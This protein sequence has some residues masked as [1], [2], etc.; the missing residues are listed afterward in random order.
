MAGYQPLYIRN[1]QVGLV[2]SRENFLLPEDAY[3][4]LENALI[5]RERIQRKY[6]SQ[7]LGRL[8]R[9]LTA[10]SF[11]N[12]SAAGA[13]KFTFD[14]GMGLRTATSI[15]A[16]ETN[17]QITPGNIVNFT[18]TIGAP[19][20]QTLTD[21]LGT[22]VLT[23]TGAGPITSASIS[24]ASTILTL[25]FSGVAGASAATF[26]GDYYPT[27]SVM[28]LRTEELVN[29]AFDQTIA[30]DTVYS[31]VYDSIL[32]HYVEFEPGTTWTGSTTEFFW[33]TNYWISA[34][35][36]KIFWVTN[37][38]DPIRFTNGQT[39]SQ[40]FNFSPIIN[41]A[42]ALLQN[43][44][45][46][47]PYRGRLV[48]FNTTESG[49][50][51]GTFTNRIRWAAIGTP[52][53]QVYGAVI[54]SFNVNAW[55]DDIRGQGGFL[56]IPTSEDITAVG[57]V[58]DNCV[59]YCERSTWQLRYTGR[60]IAPFIIERVNS[61]LGAQSLFS[62]V[63]FDTSLVGIGDK[64]IVE[65]DSYKS[66][67]IDTKI[68]DL[69]FTFSNQNEDTS[70]VHGIRDFVSRIAYWTYLDDSNNLSFPNKR[71]VY[72]YYNDSWAI[73]D[74]SF[75]C[76]GTFQLT[77]ERTWLNTPIPWIECDF[78][79]LAEP[80]GDPSIVAGNQQGFVQIVGNQLN[81]T[82][83]N[84]QSLSIANITPNVT[85][86]TEL[87]VPNHNLVT[88]AIIL[89]SGILTGTSF[90]NLNGG[91]FS[92]IVIDANN[93]L[94]MIY[95]AEDGQFSLPQLDPVPATPYIGNGVIAIRDNFDI[96]SKKFNV[97]EQGQS[98]QLGYID[99]LMDAT[100]SGAITLN[101]YMDYQ[102]NAAT[103]AF[104]QNEISGSDPP[105][106]D[107]FFNTIIQ[108]SQNGLNTLGG[109]KFFQRVFCPT[110]ANFITIEFTLSNAQ[111]NG[112]EQEQDVQIDSQ[113]IWARP[114]GRLTAG[115]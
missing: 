23:I 67:R 35:H 60:S 39:G 3:P 14:I 42:G 44:L 57:F 25:T 6:G 8:E 84:Q 37:N 111:M 85:T 45:A 54:T 41:A 12:I 51:G 17:A 55:R 69:V 18:I 75:T 95:N 114:A 78:T 32:N 74:D 94:L 81:G 2:Q 56:D 36:F 73:F 49:V 65:C 90:A 68:P 22:G 71:L 70:N 113:V 105:A 13:G 43:A 72:N 92:I 4:I 96:V 15:T 83:T 82:T 98:I 26:T 9:S 88:G 5:F 110:R 87:T 29:S 80:S 52:F 86:A 16:A 104:P 19:I 20:S 102:N 76:F 24:Y 107:D 109:E 66:E 47:L 58:R 46:L 11:G 64:G 28:G 21:T 115:Y 61:E 97:V 38:H 59:I 99:L 50:D 89:I 108:T 30:F 33:S 1:N 93:F 100:N 91:V 62:A 63:Q 106:P 101:V 31:Y 112:L 48:A 77:Q 27:L 103:N 7:F 34:N 53:T 10:A 79:W 40:W